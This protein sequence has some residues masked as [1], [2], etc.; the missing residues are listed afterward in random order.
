MGIFKDLKNTTKDLK[1]LTDTGKQ[2]QAEKYG[3]TNPFKQMSQGISE[4][5]AAVQ[6]IQAD[7]AKM[8]HLLANGIA[9][10]ATITQLRDTGMQV[11]YQPQF[12]IDLMVTIEGR[13]PY[14]AT[15]RQ[16]VAMSV[17]P[18][19]QPGATMPVHVDPADSSSLMIG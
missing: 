17:L 19:F 8:Q 14:Q 9:G 5:N 2:M 18:Q 3:T 13:D 7:Q 10:T 1:E 6:S 11:N 15:V 12:D 16:V 4:A